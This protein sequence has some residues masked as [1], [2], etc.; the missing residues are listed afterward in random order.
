MVLE[1]ER[2]LLRKWQESDAEDL[3]ELAKDPKVG[4]IAGWM[5]HKNVEESREIIEK[6][7]SRDETYAVVLKETGKAVGCVGFNFGANGNVPLTDQEGELGY[8]LGVSFWGRGLI[9]EAAKEVIR[10]GFEE[11]HLAKIWCCCAVSNEQSKRVQEKCGFVFDHLEKDVKM[12]LTGAIR[13]EQVCSLK[14]EQW[15]KSAD[16]KY[17]EHAE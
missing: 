1:T 7:L 14:R 11:L 12:E 17:M 5:P 10:H 9:P 15:E 6:I 8:W 16:E 2:L 3:Y 13:D 4:P